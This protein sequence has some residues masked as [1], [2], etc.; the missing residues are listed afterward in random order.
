[1]PAI[2]LLFEQEMA[3]MNVDVAEFIDFE[4]AWDTG[5]IAHVLDKCDAPGYTLQE[6]EGSRRGQMFN[7]ASGGNLPNEGQVELHLVSEGQ[8]VNSTF[9]VTCV[10]KP[11]WS[12]STVLDNLGDED[13]EVVFKRKEAVVRGADGRILARAQRRG[14]LYVSK[15]RMRNP[16]HPSFTR[17]A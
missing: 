6:S 1:M 9:Q 3:V 12:I 8:E 5:S 2:N 16:H 14:G 11:L 10:T 13:S 7:D 15:M 17:P 4:V